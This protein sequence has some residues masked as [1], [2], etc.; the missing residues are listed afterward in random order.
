MKKLLLITHHGTSNKYLWFVVDNGLFN[1]NKGKIFET[2]S[3]T[4]LGATLKQTC[5]DMASVFKLWCDCCQ[6]NTYPTETF[7]DLKRFSPKILQKILEEH[8]EIIMPK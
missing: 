8:P 3:S 2:N 6:D 4:Y 5:M 1:P 7:Y